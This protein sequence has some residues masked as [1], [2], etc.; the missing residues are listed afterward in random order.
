M[1][2]FW[3]ITFVLIFAL[4]SGFYITAAINN[5]DIINAGL[6][7]IKFHDEIINYVKNNKPIASSYKNKSSFYKYKDFGITLTK[8][9]EKIKEIS[10]MKYLRKHNVRKNVKKYNNYFR[11]NGDIYIISEYINGISIHKTNVDDN[12][13]KQLMN[14]FFLLD[15]AL[16]YNRDLSPQNMLIDKDDV[17][18]IDFDYINFIN[19]KGCIA[20]SGM[21]YDFCKDIDDCLKKYIQENSFY[22]DKDNPYHDINLPFPSNLNNF[23]YRTLSDILH[24]K[25]EENNEKETL[26]FKNYLKQ[27]A[28]YH[29]KRYK[30]YKRIFDTHTPISQKLKKGL[31]KENAA[32]NVLKID[33]HYIYNIEYKKII[34]KFLSYSFR[35]GN[36]GQTDGKKQK[37]KTNKRIK[38][39]FN[40]IEMNLKRLENQKE[41]NDDINLYVQTQYEW[42]NYWKDYN[43]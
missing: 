35:H 34:I 2:Q 19:N 24:N 4:C 28:K 1:K 15:K 29:K 12:H 17:Y 16:L 8:K 7:Q 10:V 18:L 26:F 41:I 32:A 21:E 43:N 23:E 13:I 22:E 9:E 27:K 20:K 38:E 33:N 25:R 36:D 42:V 14:L 6:I 40:D 31:E 39:L 37:D 11:L 3:I 5:E 30:E